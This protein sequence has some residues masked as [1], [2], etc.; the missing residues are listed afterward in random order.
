MLGG[1]PEWSETDSSHVVSRPKK[2]C[3]LFLV[4][5]LRLIKVSKPWCVPKRTGSVNTFCGASVNSQTL[6]SNL[7]LEVSSQLVDAR[8][9]TT[10]SFVFLFSLLLGVLATNFLWVRTSAHIVA[11]SKGARPWI[12]SARPWILAYC[13]LFLGLVNFR[14][15]QK[16]G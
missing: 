15:I 5:S 11:K 4:R 1:Y 12:C 7:A 3:N 13:C 6:H 14:N 8:W 2:N 9:H 16:G 10:F